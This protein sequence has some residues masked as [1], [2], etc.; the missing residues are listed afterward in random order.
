M[1]SN[2]WLQVLQF[3]CLNGL[4]G[5][6]VYLPLS[7]GQLSLGSGGFAAIG[8]YT[9]ALLVQKAGW[10]LALAVPVAALL[11][12]AVAVAVGYPALRLRG[13]YL[14]IATL[15]F[16]EVVRVVATN[17]EV[18]GGALGLKNIPNLPALVRAWLQAHG[19]VPAGMSAAQAANWAVLAL[20]ALLL[21]LAVLGCWLLSGS[22]YGRALA[23]LRA[24]EVAAEAA[25]IHP[26]YFKLLAFV[27]GSALA[28]LAGALWA[29]TTFALSPGDFGFARSVE[30]LLYVM[31]GGSQVPLGPVLGAGVVQLLLEGL[32]DLRL[33]GERLADWRLVIY[34]ALMMALVAVRPQGLLT[35]GLLSRRARG[36]QPP[37]PP[38]PAAGGAGG[39]RTGAAGE[40][41]P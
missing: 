2:Y 27:L 24:D 36:A 21:V 10:P 1:L 35:P 19:L 14:A 11:A 40:V 7:A 33:G 5:L 29:H 38:A 31:L 20:Y 25:G 6:S 17:L 39:A 8:G 12:A 22:R 26:A 16:G 41:A 32:R 23:A 18:T 15:G 13:V 28:G 30:M 4:L 34:G 37:V 9:S 3:I